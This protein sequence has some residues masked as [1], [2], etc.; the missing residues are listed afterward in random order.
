MVINRELMSALCWGPGE[1]GQG[2]GKNG[3][4]LLSSNTQCLDQR[5]FQ[6][7]FMAEAAQQQ[8]ALCGD[9]W[10]RQATSVRCFGGTLCAEAF[11]ALPVPV[12]G[13]SVALGVLK[14]RLSSASWS[15]ITCKKLDP[16]MRM[17]STR[18]AHPPQLG[19]VSFLKI[20][21]HHLM[22]SSFHCKH[23]R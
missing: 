5:G 23:V 10:R 14:H 12:C 1:W 11:R 9:A 7:A 8:V 2:P 21:A 16:S 17:C 4:L 20:L 3:L 19:N 6:G 13:V 18:R 22:Q 15:T